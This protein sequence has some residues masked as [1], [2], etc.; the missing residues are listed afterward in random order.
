MVF[1]DDIIHEFRTWVDGNRVKG[2]NGFGE[3]C[4]F[5]PRDL[6]NEYWI[7][8]DAADRI[9]P[10]LNWCECCLP[11][12]TISANLLGIFSTLVYT[13]HRPAEIKLIKD[14][15]DKDIDDNVFPLGCKPEVF[16][17]APDDRKLWEQFSQHQ[18]QFFPVRF[19]DKIGRIRLYRKRLLRQTILPILWEETLSGTSEDG[20]SAMIKKCKIHGSSRL[21][22][23]PNVSLLR[24]G[25]MAPANIVIG[26]GHNHH[27]RIPTRRIRILVP[28]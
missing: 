3:T 15:Y 26:I 9:Y 21:K 8:Q 17:D 7:P 23:I 14:F 25:Q 4:Y 22:N 28:S 10:I 1:I 12:P 5:I 11:V 19:G 24:N 16:T 6:L 27:Q 18:F 20:A 2:T 13:S